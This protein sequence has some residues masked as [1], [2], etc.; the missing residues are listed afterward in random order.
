LSAVTFCRPLA[1]D[2]QP[3]VWLE[4]RTVTAPFILILNILYFSGPDCIP[5]LTSAAFNLPEGTF[6]PNLKM[7]ESNGQQ[8][9]DNSSRA[10]TKTLPSTAVPTNPLRKFVEAALTAVEQR[11]VTGF[12]GT[13]HLL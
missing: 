6:C 4:S 11:T 3:C 9:R 2:F 5:A 1:V 12:A 13:R 7:I 8:T 10:G